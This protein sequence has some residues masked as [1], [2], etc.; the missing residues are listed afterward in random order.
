MLHHILKI[1]RH[2]NAYENHELLRNV[3]VPMKTKNLKYWREIPFL[4]AIV[5]ILDPRAKMTGFHKVLQRLS[6]LNGTDYS[7][8]PSCIRNQLTK[9]YQIYQAKFG[10][11]CLT[12][13]PQAGS[14]SSKETEAWD[15]I[16]GDDE[17]YSNTDTSGTAGTSTFTDI[18]ELT[19]Y[20]DSDTKTKFGPDFNILIWWQCHNRTNHI[21]SIL[22]KHVMIVH[23]SPISL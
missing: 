17:T 2:L 15:D 12:P 8:Y 9:M 21:L 3:V 20:L 19:Y 1:A 18:S 22:A 14:G 13:Q 4:Y 10:G 11:V 7:R 5:F 6:S 16:Y 23:I